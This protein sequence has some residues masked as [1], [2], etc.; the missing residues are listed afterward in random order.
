MSVLQAISLTVMDLSQ[1]K[2]L[3]T[4]WTKQAKQISCLD[5]LKTLKSEVILLSLIIN[6]MENNLQQSKDDEMK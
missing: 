3:K 4:T 2:M 1:I 6:K 5:L